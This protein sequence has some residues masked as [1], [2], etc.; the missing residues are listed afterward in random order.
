LEVGVEYVRQTLGVSPHLGG[1]H[2]RMG[3]HNSLL[4]LGEKVYLEVIAINPNAPPPNRPRW[5]QLD[6]P[7]PS[8]P[9]RL[10]TWMA[11]TDGIY[12]AITASP[13]PLGEI[14]PMSRG[15][16]NW[17]ITLPA[18][19]SLPLQGIAPVLIQWTAGAH[20]TATLPESGCALVRLEGFHP[21][22][23]EVIRMLKSIGFAGGFRVS[24]L[25]SDQKPY[26]VAHIQTPAGV[27]QLSAPNFSLHSDPRHEAPRAG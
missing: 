5:F 24:A 26:L 4:K 27:R 9:V 14:E 17:L 7:D 8:H 19:G 25:P 1:E 23:K 18:D 11:R 13:I 21:E 15:Q 3:T 6:E 12:A 22:A 2:P 16:L 20:P 10:A